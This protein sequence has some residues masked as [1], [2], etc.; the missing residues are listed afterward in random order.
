MHQEV[1]VVSAKIVE[2]NG[3][4]FCQSKFQVA[5]V[6]GCA[7]I[8][9]C[10]VAVVFDTIES[11]FSRVTCSRFG[12]GFCCLWCSVLFFGVFVFGAFDSFAF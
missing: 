12:R 11:S 2:D 10:D 7:L 9:S 4:G 1:A 8:S 6:V 3:Y 5:F